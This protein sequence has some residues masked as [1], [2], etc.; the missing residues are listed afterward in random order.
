MRLQYKFQIY[1]KNINQWGLGIAGWAIAPTRRLHDCACTLKQRD[2]Y[3][4][5]V[6]KIKRCSL[7]FNPCKTDVAVKVAIENAKNIL[8]R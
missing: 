4:Q 1:D 8:Y 3:D 6:N 2:Y 5:N 7:R